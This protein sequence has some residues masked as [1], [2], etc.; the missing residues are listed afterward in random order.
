MVRLFT[1]ACF[2]LVAGCTTPPPAYTPADASA[3]LSAPQ[4][5]VGDYWE[6]AVRDGWTALPRGNYR[7]EVT[8]ADANGTVVQLTH[9]GRILDT[10]VYAPG[11]NPREA[12]LPNT[13]RFRY[14]PTFTA[15]EYPLAPGKSW[16]T[17]VRSTDVVTG[18]TYNTHIKARVIGWERVSV[19]A[20]QFD[21]LRIERAVFAGNM[22]GSRTQE[23]I[24]ETEWY[25]PSVRHPVR[26]Q[27]NSQHFDSSRG[28]GDGGGE[29]PLRIRGDYLI[30]ELVA[31]SR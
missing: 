1:A 11:W 5:K 6:Y 29:Y 17:V 19:P 12:P 21:A 18:R 7:Y 9:E 10:F 27:S 23:E 20:G 2:V 24:E 15:Y 25:A 13:Q 16:T 8:S 22:E 26:K 31:Y 3:S 28:G 14:N 30:G 4:A